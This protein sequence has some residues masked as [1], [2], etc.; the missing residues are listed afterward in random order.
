MRVQPTV[1]KISRS[2]LAL[3]LALLLHPF[4]GSAGTAGETVP[5][6]GRKVAG[7][8]AET[9]AHLES[10]R[11]IRYFLR[12]DDKWKSA[13]VDP[14]SPVL[15]PGAPL[16]LLPGDGEALPRVLTVGLEGRLLQ[17]VPT[18]KEPQVSAVAD[19]VLP[20]GADFVVADS[21][22][23][24][25]VFV[26]DQDGT[27]WEI[28]RASGEKHAVER[29][30]DRLLPGSAVRALPGEANELFLV[31][32]RG[33]L[34]S[35]VRDPVVR[36]K[37][38][39]LIGTDFVAG[40]DVAVWRRPDASRDL[41]LA[42][43]NRRGELYAARQE[44]AGW[45]LEMAPGWVL[46]PGC[47]VGSAHTPLNLRLC[48]VTS[49]GTLQEMNRLNTEWTEQTIVSGFAWKSSALFIAG[50][51]LLRG[52]D[53]AGNLAAFQSVEEVWSGEVI[54]ADPARD[55]GKLVRRD[56]QSAV[57]LEPVEIELEN[58]TS[59]TL[60]VRLSDRRN[61]TV[62]LELTITPSK[63][64]KLQVDRDA[65]GVLHDLVAVTAADGAKSEQTRDEPTAP[66]CLYDIEVLTLRAAVPYVDLRQMAWP[67]LSIRENCRFSLGRFSIPAGDQLPA[68]LKIDLVPA[69]VAGRVR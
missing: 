3:G 4:A 23:K 21:G 13:V 1:A 39:R 29:R 68:E 28:H 56:W 47:S 54:P 10:P 24:S 37:G 20:P 67:P 62:N 35:Y 48:A 2:A 49:R 17:V 9:I 7:L 19:V 27:L 12:R 34:V 45:R 51:P 16:S 64:T 42:S 52:V 25:L 32:R 46:P 57:P 6:N 31:D 50:G 53:A 38:P 15:V 36:W 59:D 5:A 61:P 18:L 26:V 58:R 69:A 63:S 8:G 60:F 65:G 66:Q 40:G 22:G 55:G 11:T 41:Q 30:A 33:N 43:V 14:G 44:A